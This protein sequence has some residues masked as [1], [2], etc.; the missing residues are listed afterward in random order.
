MNHNNIPSQD[1]ANTNSLVGSI[2]F[3]LQKT[4][5]NLDDAL[6]VMVTGYLAPTETQPAFVSC[7]SLIQIVGTGGDPNPPAIYPKIPVLMLGGGGFIINF[8]IKK[9]D[10]GWIKAMD[11]DIS[12][13]IQS[14]VAA[15]PN[16][17]KM[18]SFS[19]GIFIPQAARQFTLNPDDKDN[20]VIQTVDGTS[21]VSI[22]QGKIT[23]SAP[24]VEIDGA[25]AV[26]INTPLATLT[27]NLAV[28]GNIT[29]TG[30]ITPG[31]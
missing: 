6:P 28:I 22:G 5:Q 16:T 13:Y 29:A 3:A 19:N 21:K 7:Q 4:I 20:L 11:R 9:G 2:A 10:I 14:G 17:D 24:I 15:I 23:V 30:T 18:H 26:N 1:P 12:L 8:P 31:V 27:G 25:T